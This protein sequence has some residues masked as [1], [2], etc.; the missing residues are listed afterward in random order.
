M[1]LDWRENSLESWLLL[2]NFL[3]GMFT[4]PASFFLSETCEG[5]SRE[6]VSESSRA[7]YSHWRDQLTTDECQDNMSQ[8]CSVETL[9]T[10][11]YHKRASQIT[12]LLLIVIG[13]TKYI[14]Q[15][16]KII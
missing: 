12:I 6:K 11:Y 13:A 3:Y 8:K 10:L 9:E 4:L 2:R 14:I 1:R 15:I 16:I 7:S 5:V